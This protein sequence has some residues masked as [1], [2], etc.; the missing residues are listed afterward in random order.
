M[1]EPTYAMTNEILE[2]ITFVLAYPNVL[3]RNRRRWE[4]KVKLSLHM[5]LGHMGG[6]NSLEGGTWLAS[7][8][9]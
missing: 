8:P 9:G 4:V 2:P 6:W 7:G 1:P 3:R 5:A